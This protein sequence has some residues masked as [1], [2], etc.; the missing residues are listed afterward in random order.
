[1]LEET[2]LGEGGGMPRI[3]DEVPSPERSLQSIQ[4]WAEEI[5]RTGEAENQRDW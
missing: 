2:A 5:A 4:F 3:K 1:L